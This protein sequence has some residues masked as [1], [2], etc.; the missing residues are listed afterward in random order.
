M[1][2][3][4]FGTRIPEVQT[5]PS[6]SA[7]QGRIFSSYLSDEKIRHLREAVRLFLRRPWSEQL[8]EGVN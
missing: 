5:K 4:T 1:Q 6:D 3:V 8:T 7:F 2:W